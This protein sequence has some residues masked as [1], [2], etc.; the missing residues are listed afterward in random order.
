MIGYFMGKSVQVQKA[1]RVDK[2]FMKGVAK[3]LSTKGFSLPKVSVLIGAPDWPTSVICG[4]LRI[5]LFQCL[6]GT[7]PVIVVLTPCVLAGAFL[8]GP[9]VG[10]DEE[11]N[12]GIWSTLASSALAMSAAVQLASGVSALYFVQD[13]IHRYD[14]ELCAPRPEHAAVLA[15]RQADKERDDACLSVLEWKALP[16]LQKVI[17]MV[18][19]TSMLLSFFVFLFMDETNF[20]PFQVNNRIGDPYGKGGLA[21]D[22][23]SIVLWPG[24]AAQG[25]F[26]FGFVLHLVFMFSAQRRARKYLAQQQQQYQP[27]LA[28]ETQGQ[29][30]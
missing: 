30:V 8:A 12:E 29:S 9:N 10:S 21:G 27:K 18:S 13:T 2:K 16:K 23:W 17:I 7:T 4:I 28:E 3:I 19:V 11:D 22:A 25:V 1:C 24:W 5:N 20:R 15:L 6:L 14:D 26:T